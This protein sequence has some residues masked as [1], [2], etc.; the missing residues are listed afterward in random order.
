MPEGLTK[1]NDLR[2]FNGLVH[3]KRFKK[4]FNVKALAN[5]RGQTNSPS[6]RFLALQAHISQNF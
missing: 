2:I 1:P 3:Q 5:L 6:F 4:K